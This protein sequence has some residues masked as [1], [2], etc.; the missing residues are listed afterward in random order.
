[1]RYIAIYNCW[2]LCLFL[3]FCQT[4]NDFRLQYKLYVVVEKFWTQLYTWGEH[5]KLNLDTTY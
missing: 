5:K 2:K 3:Y 1:M 4:R